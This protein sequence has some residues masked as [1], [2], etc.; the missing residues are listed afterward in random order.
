MPRPGKKKSP[1]Q[2][3]EAP[4]PARKP[5]IAEEVDES[6]DEEIDEDEAFNSEDERM[7]GHFFN[8]K[9]D[10]EDEA[11]SD[12]DDDD[13]DEDD[14]DDGGQYM[15]NLL[16]KLGSSGNKAKVVKESSQM[17]N[18][19]ESEYSSSISKKGLTLDNL[20]E[21]L[22]D[23]Q[24]FRDLQKTFQK[25]PTTT[26]AP[27]DKVVASRTQRKLVYEDQVKNIAGWT[28]AVQEN[29]Q[30][31]TLDFKPKERMEVTRDTLIDKFE[32]TTEFEKELEQA[33]AE[34][35]QQD[36]EAVLKAEEQALQDDLGANRLTMEEYKKRRGQLAQVRA[37]MFYHEQ[38]RHHMKKIKSKKYRRIRKKQRERLKE[39]AIEA[40]T[41]DDVDLANELKE[42][43]EVSRIQER[44]TLAHKNTS[45]WAKRILKRGKNVDMESRK[46]LSAQLKRGDDLRRKMMGNEDGDSDNDSGEDLIE[47]ARKVLADTEE[48]SDPTH[49]KAGLFQ[50]SFMQKGIK[51]QREKAQ[52]EARKLLKELEAN[53]M[54]DYDEA[55]KNDE[56]EDEAPT[57]KGKVA[58]EKEMKEVLQQGEMVAT[59]LEF[60]NSNAIATSCGIEIDISSAE[61]ENVDDEEGSAASQEDKVKTSGGN[62]EHV[63]TMAVTRTS[64]PE[65]KADAEQDTRGSGAKKRKKATQAATE[66]KADE[67]ETN[68][69]MKST[70]SKDQN[71]VASS[72]K[73]KN[74]KGMVDVEG[75]VD[76]LDA[77]QKTATERTLR[78]GTADDMTS[79][80]EDSGDKKISMLTQEELVRRAFAAPSEKEVQEEFQKEK[81]AMAAED[82]PT[83]KVA[84]DKASL[85][86][87]GWGSWAGAGAPP[88]RRQKLPKK[89]QAPTQK[90]PKRK[91]KDDRKPDVILNQKRM[92][93]TANTFMLEDVPHPYSSRAEYEQ[94][95][96][97]GVGREWNVTSAYKNMTRP[98]IL[99]RSG[100]IIQP[101]S[102]KV[103]VSRGP[104][105]F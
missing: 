8:K 15:L 44:M 66:T 17:A 87:A 52:E 45:K 90:D 69:W 35:G 21:G 63:S 97:G 31:E 62:S 58:T 20:M 88:P 64:T 82:D 48:A 14:D 26:P 24:G 93:K 19:P 27:L 79:G 55:M 68:P 80:V 105:K 65:K 102:K 51:K 37:L 40:A 10:D 13:S 39:S 11:T 33:L 25:K 86:V 38:K 84:K 4:P 70:D 89:L 32:P 53:E 61:K 74:K 16:D 34:A 5:E 3:V 50:L 96:L 103:K 81:D 94:A 36:E 92:K 98:E 1:K 95:M 67:D 85:D 30:A 7:Y 99:T 100:K 72:K 18:I 29:R 54:D 22:Q 41:E 104:A 56:S 2:V 28:K 78:D 42:K 9:D 83:R 23:T 47:S 43:E 60:G 49:G 77:G 57:K 71:L 76:I 91:R 101:I 6:D 73:K 59:S 46:A 12:D 75:A